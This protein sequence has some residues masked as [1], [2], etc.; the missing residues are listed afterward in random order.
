MPSG[1]MPRVAEIG[2]GMIGGAVRVAGAPLV[3]IVQRM[4]RTGIAMARCLNGIAQQGMLGRKLPVWA[5]ETFNPTVTNAYVMLA[6]AWSAA[7]RERLFATVLRPVLAAN[8]PAARTGT[9]A[10]VAPNSARAPRAAGSGADGG[11]VD[12]HGR[13]D[14]ARVG[15]EAARQYAYW[16]EYAKPLRVG[17]KG[18]A[19]AVQQIDGLS[20]VAV[21]AQIGKY[22]R[23]AA[24]QL[25]AEADIV[26]IE[27]LEKAALALCPPPE[28]A[29]PA[30]DD[31]P[32]IAPDR[33]EVADASGSAVRTDRS[34][35]VNWAGAPDAWPPQNLRPDDRP[36]GTAHDPPGWS[37]SG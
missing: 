4:R 18:V 19:V 23:S 15:E 8:V 22:L 28:S 24:E 31:A 12:W 26:R 16:L 14:P 7:L 33:A 32:D 20:D 29:E 5:P 25:G 3:G 11:V 34:A 9:Q 30:A 10:Q 36:R 27:A 2:G 35:A 17:P 1:A 13:S 21:V 37:R 6:V